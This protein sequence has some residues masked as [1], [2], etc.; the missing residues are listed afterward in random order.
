M[1]NNI[2][3]IAQAK[4]LVRNLS[5]LK[6]EWD[7]EISE[8]RVI[9]IDLK[10]ETSKQRKNVLI[11]S[12]EA[13]RINSGKNVRNKYNS[14]HKQ[15]AKEIRA[16]LFTALGKEISETPHSYERITNPFSLE[17]VIRE[18]SDLY[19]KLDN[20]KVS[21]QDSKKTDDIDSNPK[22]TTA[23][24]IV[25]IIISV[26]IMLAGVFFFTPL[27]K[28]ISGENAK[29][30]DR[31]STINNGDIINGGMIIINNQMGD[32][33]ELPTNNRIVS[34]EIQ[35][36]PK[37]KPK[38]NITFSNSFDGIV[39]KEISKMIYADVDNQF[40][41]YIVSFETTGEVIKVGNTEMYQVNSG[42]LV[43]RINGQ[44]TC[45]FEDLFLLPIPVNS[46]SSIK[47]NSKTRVVNKVNQNLKEIL[48][49]INSLEL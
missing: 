47:K 46:L 15:D 28:Y 6:E 40:K 10:H 43:L 49:C 36:T 9:E 26:I 16:N 8:E 1:R 45:D 22:S 20:I 32:D 24:S 25:P 4:D 39:K 35:S 44:I 12:L 30:V 48:K 5:A 21:N 38:G 2:S 23:S 37:V 33:E 34:K 11:K 31:S 3:L 27:R 29:V 14:Y 19:I 41:D 17:E 42:H 13:K 7:H 18:I